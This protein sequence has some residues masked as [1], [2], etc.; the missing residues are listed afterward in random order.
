MI[1]QTQ[2]LLYK[3]TYRG[4]LELA[5]DAKDQCTGVRGTALEGGERDFSLK[6]RIGYARTL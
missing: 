5:Y 4:L 3:K 2:S 6:L 1:R